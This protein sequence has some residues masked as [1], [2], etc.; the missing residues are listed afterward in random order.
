M[1]G[2]LVAANSS[3]ILTHLNWGAS[4]VVHDFYQ[5]FIRP[6][7]S[8]KHYVLVGRLAT[9][10]KGATPADALADTFVGASPR[11]SRLGSGSGSNPRR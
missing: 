11:I 10:A 7:A 5:Q 4:Y 9:V 6:G 8:E 1:L 3:T 2:G